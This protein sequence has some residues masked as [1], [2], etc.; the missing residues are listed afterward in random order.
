MSSIRL[1]CASAWLV[2]AAQFGLLTDAASAQGQPM[3]PAEVLRAAQGASGDIEQLQAAL[4]SPDASVRMATFSA[5]VDSNNPAL[6]S[7]AINTGHASADASMRDVAARAALK[8]IQTLIVEPSTTLTGEALAAQTSFSNNNGLR[9]VLTKIDWRS[10]Q[11]ET[12]VG[13][14]V[15][16][17]GSTITFQNAFCQGRLSAVEGSWVYEGNVA[18]VNG[19]SRLTEKMRTSLR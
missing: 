7:L 4:K 17:S 16:V 19:P 14:R 9:I 15:Q 1:G 12:Y 5:M 10:G 6:S 13:G 18:C 3:T 11:A 2:L 8:E